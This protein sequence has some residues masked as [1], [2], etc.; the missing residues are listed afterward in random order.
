MADGGGL[1][2]KT[3]D[4]HTIIEKGNLLQGKARWCTPLI[5]TLRRQSHCEFKAN[6]VHILGSRLVSATWWI[7]FSK[8]RKTHKVENNV[9]NGTGLVSWKKKKAKNNQT[10][11]S[12]I[13]GQMILYIT[14][15]TL[16]SYT[17]H[18]LT[19][20]LHSQNSSRTLVQTGLHVLSSLMMP[21]LGRVFSLPLHVCTCSFHCIKPRLGGLL[22][23]VATGWSCSFWCGCPQP[24][25]PAY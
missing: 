19:N 11:N 22:V 24:Q 4:V 1:Q 15:I 3:E 25:I 5:P 14:F 10:P 23:S 8:E 7:L 21:M 12:Q 6:L 2:E 13:T 18:T 16:A 9:K 17:L 20:H